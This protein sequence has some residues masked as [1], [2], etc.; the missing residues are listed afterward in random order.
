MPSRETGAQEPRIRVL[1]QRDDFDL[2]ESDGADAAE[3]AGFYGLRPDPWQRDLLQVWLTRDPYDMYVCTS[4]GLSVPR[5]N[6]KNAVLEMRELYGLTVVGEKILHTAHRVDTARKAFLRLASFFE[7]PEYPELMDMVVCIRRTN[8]QE[9]ITLN[10]GGMI[11]FSSRVN[12]GA[13]GSTYDLV[14]FD[15]AQELTDDQIEAIMSTMA[16]APLGNRQLIFTGTPPSPVSPGTVFRRRR[17]SAISGKD[18]R[19]SW[20]EWSVEDIGDTAD[21][22][23]WYAT[24]PALG[25][26]LDEEFTETEHNTLTTDGFARERLG[27]WSDESGVNAALSRVKWEACGISPERAP[28]PDEDNERIAYGV[29]FTPDG[30]SMALSAAVRHP[31]RKTLV[32]CIEFGLIVNGINRVADWLVERKSICSVVVIDGKSHTAA[33]VQKL[34]DAGFPKKGIVVARPDDVISAASMLWN[35]VDQGEIYHVSPTDLDKSAISAQKRNIGN[36]GGWGFG[37]GTFDCAP[38]ESVSLAHWG[39]IKTKRNPRRKMRVG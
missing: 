18:E 30:A 24:N 9:S 27:W 13:R 37:S 8:G 21:R 19:M 36:N 28:K 7:N 31:D 33:L 34:L 14:V 4:C 16:A 38:I 6:G 15:E 29:K 11:E 39:V 10:N 20:H 22:S 1:P 35:A 2:L 25:I 12:G 23:R 17:D 3:L 32:E 5:Q 26:R